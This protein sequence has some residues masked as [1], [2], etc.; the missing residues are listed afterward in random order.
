[1]V[2]RIATFRWIDCVKRPACRASIASTA[3]NYAKLREEMLCTHCVRLLALRILSAVI[4]SECKANRHNRSEIS[5]IQPM[6]KFLQLQ[7][8]SLAFPI[9]HSLIQILQS[10]IPR[11]HLGINH[12]IWQTVFYAS[13][14]FLFTIS[15]S[16]LLCKSFNSSSLW[17]TNDRHHCVVVG[18]PFAKPNEI[19]SNRPFRITMPKCQ[20]ATT[21]NNQSKLGEE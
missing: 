1:M 7:Q 18:L 10:L 20:T 2:I 13:L 3:L 4:R 12:F 8:P 21:G 17:C 16:T 19:N 14:R 5:G 15:S 6:L 11:F 9:A